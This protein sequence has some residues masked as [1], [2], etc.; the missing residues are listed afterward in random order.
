M[1]KARNVG[2]KQS[3][4]V[5]PVAAAPDPVFDD[6]TSSDNGSDNEE[7]LGQDY[8]APVAGRLMG[9]Q[10]MPRFD[11][12]KIRPFEILFCANI[13]YPCRV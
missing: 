10:N 8:E 5:M 7:P 6:D 2:L 12:Y 13:D 1:A 3:K 4:P 9:V 11:L